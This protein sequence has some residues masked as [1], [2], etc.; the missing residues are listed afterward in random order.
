MNP[1]NSGLNL[2][3]RMMRETETWQPSQQHWMQTRLL[4]KTQKSTNNQNNVFL[5]VN[6]NGMIKIFH[7]QRT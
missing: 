4:R 6:S 1:G 2:Y 7:S 3:P 5:A